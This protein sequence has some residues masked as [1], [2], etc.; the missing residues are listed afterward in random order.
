MTPFGL[1]GGCHNNTTERGVSDTTTG[2]ACS[3][4]ATKNE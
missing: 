3:E 1:S 2:G 4:G